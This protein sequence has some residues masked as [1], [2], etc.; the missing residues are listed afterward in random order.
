MALTPGQLPS[1]YMCE[2]KVNAGSFPRSLYILFAKV[3]SLSLELANWLHC[4]PS[5]SGDLSLSAALLLAILGL[6]KHPPH[7][8]LSAG[9]GDHSYREHACLA[10]ILLN[11]WFPALEIF[12]Y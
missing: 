4:C 10:V 8:S 3:F 9:A 5:S 11:A 2:P 6:Q 7:P 12:L 1:Q